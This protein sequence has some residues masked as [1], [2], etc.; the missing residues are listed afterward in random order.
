MPE[1]IGQ[2]RRSRADSGAFPQIVQDDG[3]EY[4][5]IKQGDVPGMTYTQVKDIALPGVLETTGQVTFDDRRSRRSSRASQGRI[6]DVRVSQW[7][8]VGAVSRSSRS[9]APTS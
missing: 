1:R 2:S 7:D 6:E 8:D 5:L 3:H 4:L 9:T